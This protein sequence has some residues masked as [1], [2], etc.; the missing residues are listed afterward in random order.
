M[1]VVWRDE[2]LGDGARFFPFQLFL[3]RLVVV[4]SFLHAGE[5]EASDEFR[6]FA[7]QRLKIMCGFVY[8]SLC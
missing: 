7:L 4:V 1:V 2:R 5:K 6:V 8:V 3:P